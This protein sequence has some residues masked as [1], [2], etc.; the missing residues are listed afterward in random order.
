M[1]G[2]IIIEQTQPT[3]DEIG[4]TVS[5]AAFQRLNDASVTTVGALTGT[6]A[7]VMYTAA[8][9]D[10]IDR[11]IATSNYG[12]ATSFSRPDTP[13]TASSSSVLVSGTAFDTASRPYGRR[14]DF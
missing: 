13:P 4:N 14:N 5:V 8:W 9:F 3:F 7:R 1:T 6:N 10:G 11:P 2:D 12:A